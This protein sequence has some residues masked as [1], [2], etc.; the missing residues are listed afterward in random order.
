MELSQIHRNGLCLIGLGLALAIFVVPRL[1]P[2]TATPAPV[3]PTILQAPLP[4]AHDS[5]FEEQQQQEWDTIFDP[6]SPD[7]QKAE[8][9]QAERAFADKPNSDNAQ[10]VKAL[11]TDL[12]DQ[13]KENS[14]YEK[15]LAVLN[16]ML[17]LDGSIGTEQYWCDKG[18][19]AIAYLRAGDES[20][21]APIIDELFGNVPSHTS[22]QQHLKPVLDWYL[23]A[24]RADDALSLMYRI[25]RYDKEHEWPLFLGYSA[26]NRMAEEFEEKLMPTKAQEVYDLGLNVEVHRNQPWGQAQIMHRYAGFQ[27]RRGMKDQADTLRHDA[28]L[29]EAKVNAKDRFEDISP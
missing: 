14:Q 20:H 28:Q 29:I 6:R 17:V 16:R 11:L 26:F 22:A 8:I 18:E 23:K 5:T 25:V 27:E 4:V 2:N 9:K 10:A 19:L 1:S 3:K 13:Y 24:D 21:A 15:A 12:Y 7:H